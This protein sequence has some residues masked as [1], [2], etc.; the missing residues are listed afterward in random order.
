MKTIRT[1][2]LALAALLAATGSY[3]ATM[4]KADYAAGKDRIS[5]NYKADKATCDNFSGNAKDICVEQA[6]GK[7]SVARAELE[8]NYTG[9]PEDFNKIDVAKADANYAVSKEMCDDKG[10]NAKDVCVTEAKATHTKALADAK[11]SRKVGE[12]RKDAIDDKR[13][14]DYKVAA[15]K[16][17]TLSGDAKASCISDA[18]A[19]F[20]K[21]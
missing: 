17:E 15:E 14:A 19:R 16:C 8:A 20:N 5:A 6:K 10:G 1:S 18:K 4:T 2:A 12:A 3:A 13:D 21:S 11:L 7:E 9:K